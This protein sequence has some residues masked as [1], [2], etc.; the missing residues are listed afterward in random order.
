M[1]VPVPQGHVLLCTS[2]PSAPTRRALPAF[3]GCSLTLTRAQQEEALTTR[4]GAQKAS[5]LLAYVEGR[6]ATD[7][8]GAH[9]TSNPL[10]LSMV[11]SVFRMRGDLGMPTTV[12]ELYAVASDTMLGRGGRV[13]EE[14][15][16][17]LRRIFSRRTAQAA[18]FT[19]GS[20]T[21]RRSG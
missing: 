13:T 18:S 10:M 5:E 4:L 19:S 16:V 8:A 6:M 15:R 1:D 21:R 11:A 14:L 17:L 2:R 20:S 12:A 7:E 9:V 3:V